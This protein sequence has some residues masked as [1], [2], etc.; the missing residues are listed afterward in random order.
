MLARIL[1]KIGLPILI[2]FMS[3]ALGRINHQS[4]QKAVLVLDDLH[5]VIRREEIPCDELRNAT[6]WPEKSG[7]LENAFPAQML[8]H[9]REN[10]HQEFK[11]E[12]RFS[13]LWRP[14]FGY[15]VALS[16]FLCISTICYVVVSGN[17][18]TPEI[19]MA[20][21]E[22]TSL[23][24]IA[25]GVLGISVVKTNSEIPMAQSRPM[26]NKNH[27]QPTFIKEKNYGRSIYP[28]QAAST[29]NYNGQQRTES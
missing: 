8:S 23:W 15:S 6:R 11:A 3:S 7:E 18:R 19:I 1:G 13:K 14:A 27:I 26:F 10:L 21:V 12:D 2:R 24:G 20:L 25:L 16:W 9:L 5:S 17:Q 22:T 4:A 29:G 28:G